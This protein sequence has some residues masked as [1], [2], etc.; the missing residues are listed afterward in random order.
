MQKSQ[1]KKYRENC[2]VNLC[3]HYYSALY[4]LFLYASVPNA[5]LR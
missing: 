5:A 2:A 4:V 1:F 3:V